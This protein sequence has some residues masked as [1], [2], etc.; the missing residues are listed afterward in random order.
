M[1]MKLP[2]ILSAM[3]VALA[4]PAAMGD[5]PPPEPYKESYDRGVPGIDGDPDKDLSPRAGPFVQPG[6]MHKH[7]KKHKESKTEEQQ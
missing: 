6:Q 1:T 4:V 5:T 3:I 2:V 7:K